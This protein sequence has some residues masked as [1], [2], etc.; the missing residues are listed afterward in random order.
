MWGRGGGRSRVKLGLDPGL[1][2][3]ANGVGGEE[4]DDGERVVWWPNTFRDSKSS[5]GVPFLSLMQTE[6]LGSRVGPAQ[7]SMVT[8]EV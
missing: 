6:F 8:V 2:E 4:C 1:G 7:I 5:V 3:G